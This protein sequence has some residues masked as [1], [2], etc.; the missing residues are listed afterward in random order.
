MN[1][2]KCGVE[3][4]AQSAI[5]GAWCVYC[6]EKEEERLG[7]RLDEAVPVPTLAPTE[8]APD[9]DFA[10]TVAPADQALTPSELARAK[11]SLAP[12]KRKGHR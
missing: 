6:A 10:F 2:D 1:C 7:K 3:I 12:L 5:Q 4:A 8:P 9:D 11:E